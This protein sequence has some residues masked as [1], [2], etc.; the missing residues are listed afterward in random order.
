MKLKKLV[1]LSL[2]MII[3]VG[4]LV[5]CGSNEDAASDDK[6]KIGMIT[7][8][9]GVNDESFNQSS[10]EGLQAVEKELG[11]DKIEVKSFRINSRC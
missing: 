11:K 1:A 6:V 2:T 7:D 10:W 4:L 3:S 8:V 9:G 5:G